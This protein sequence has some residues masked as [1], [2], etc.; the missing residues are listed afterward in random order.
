M[1]IRARRTHIGW[2][3]LTMVLVNIGPDPSLTIVSVAYAV[4]IVVGIH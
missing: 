3:D 1:Q 2:M 4:D